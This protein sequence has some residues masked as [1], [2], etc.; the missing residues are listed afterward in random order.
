MLLIFFPLPSSHLIIPSHLL[1]L[2]SLLSSFIITASSDPRHRCPLGLSHY[3]L[4]FFFLVC[5][6]ASDLVSEVTLLLFFLF[7]SFLA[8]LALLGGFFWFS[9][10]LVLSGFHGICFG[11]GEGDDVSFFFFFFFFAVVGFVMNIWES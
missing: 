7:F 10:V 1:S 6:F 3:D 5:L 11:M 8:D 9:S 2:D 4:F